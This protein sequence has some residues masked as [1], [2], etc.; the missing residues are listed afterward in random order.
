VRGF[1]G[2]SA[3]TAPA[4]PPIGLRGTGLTQRE[5]EVLAMI[6]RGLD[7]GEIAQ[8]LGTS[9]KT[10]R[11]QVSSIFAKLGVKK[12]AQ[13]IVMARESGLGRES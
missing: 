4:L 10:V 5:G 2:Q 8:S 7:N 12:R 11:N 9:E 13:A 6:A 1:L 3:P